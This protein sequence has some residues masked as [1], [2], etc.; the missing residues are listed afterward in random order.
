MKNNN[1]SVVDMFK[2][3]TEDRPKID[4]RDCQEILN[5]RSIWNQFGIGAGVS[6]THRQEPEKPLKT[7]M[8]SGIT[9]CMVITNK[10]DIK[11]SVS[12]CNTVQS[13]DTYYSSLSYENCT[14]IEEKALKGYDNYKC[15]NLY[16]YN[17]V[18]NNDTVYMTIAVK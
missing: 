13:I 17:P 8:T 18:A 10:Q 15:Y 14:K 2:S 7:L 4:T 11:V 12:A 3:A 6:N 1:Y 9:E 5:S 16:R